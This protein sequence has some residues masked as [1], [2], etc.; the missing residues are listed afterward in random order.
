MNVSS[1]GHNKWSRR[2]PASSASRCFDVTLVL[3]ATLIIAMSRLE[4]IDRFQTRET[5]LT[6]PWVIRLTRGTVAATPPGP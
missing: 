2:R 1:S 6:A 5:A 4:R 3:R